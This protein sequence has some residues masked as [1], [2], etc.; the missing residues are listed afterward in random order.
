[1]QHYVWGVGVEGGQTEERNRHIHHAN[2]VCYWRCWDTSKL[3]GGQCVQLEVKRNHLCSQAYRP[4][5]P[6]T[7]DLKLIECFT[8]TRIYQQPKVN[9]LV[10]DLT[11]DRKAFVCLCLFN[12]CL[13]LIS[14]AK[15]GEC[16]LP[17]RLPGMSHMKYSYRTFAT[18]SF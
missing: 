3:M 6:W 9:T 13:N 5:Y 10:A 14:N 1:M 4:F 8:Q 11:T 2:H 12:N 17:A 16:C 7:S 15:K 18:D